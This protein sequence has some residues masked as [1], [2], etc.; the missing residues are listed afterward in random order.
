M[1]IIEDLTGC[2]KLQLIAKKYHFKRKNTLFYKMRKHVYFE[3]AFLV[4]SNKSEKFNQNIDTFSNK[5]ASN[6]I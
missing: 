3:R 5:Y 2:F 4:A 1:Q 6:P